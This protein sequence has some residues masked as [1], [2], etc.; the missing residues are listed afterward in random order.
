MNSAALKS[1]KNKR[2][3]PYEV[4]TKV[5][6][7]KLY[8]QTKDIDLVCRRYHI[9]KTLSVSFQQY[10]NVRDWLKN[11]PSETMRVGKYELHLELN[12]IFPGSHHW[13]TYRYYIF[14]RGYVSIVDWRSAGWQ[15]SLLIVN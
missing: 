5:Y 15:Q 4:T 7:V 12:Q 9:S 2:Y 10:P 14:I 6:S 3:L 8:R 13:Q 1:E 11:T